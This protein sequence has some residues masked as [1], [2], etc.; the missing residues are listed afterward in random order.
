MDSEINK[1]NESGFASQQI[2]ALHPWEFAVIKLAAGGLFYCHLNARE[3]V[4][5][6][7][8]PFLTTKYYTKK[9]QIHLF[10]LLCAC[11]FW[12]RATFNFQL[13]M[14][15]IVALHFGYSDLP[16]NKEDI[17]IA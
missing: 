14:P 10:L 13:K 3:I 8:I 7:K 16:T 6:N 9:V 2:F 4:K 5:P 17:K 11:K 1:L 15:I 12:Y